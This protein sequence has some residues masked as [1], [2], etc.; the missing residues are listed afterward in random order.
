MKYPILNKRASPAETVSTLRPALL[1]S[2]AAALG[3]D[4]G[5]GNAT[6]SLLPDQHQV[7]KAQV[8]RAGRVS[9]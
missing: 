9:S 8:V 5:V 3:A 4:R 1:H 2:L 7:V 6:N